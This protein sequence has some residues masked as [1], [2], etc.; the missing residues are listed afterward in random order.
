M[1][2]IE[3]KNI[4]YINFGPELEPDRSDLDV[5]C[6]LL[7]EDPFFEDFHLLKNR[8][9]HYGKPV[10]AVFKGEGHDRLPSTWK[11]I[12]NW[13]ETDDV[14]TLIVSHLP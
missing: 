10:V 1:G 12:R 6:V 3:S 13:K 5:I 9:L 8:V 4:G 2:N 7:D 11:V 14:Q